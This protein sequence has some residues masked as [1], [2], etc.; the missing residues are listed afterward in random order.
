MGHLEPSRSR[1]PRSTCRTRGSKAP[2]PS[3][4]PVVVVG[5]MGKELAMVVV[6]VETTMVMMMMITSTT[7]KMEMKKLDFSGGV[8]LYKSFLTESLLML[9]FKSGT[10]L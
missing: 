9:F 3:W 4:Q 8:L 2:T 10:K 5:I 1:R 6:I 7:L